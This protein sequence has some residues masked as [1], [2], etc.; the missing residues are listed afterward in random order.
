M[1]ITPKNLVAEAPPLDQPRVL[2]VDDE[3]LVL[4]SLARIFA[5]AGYQVESANDGAAA[6]ALLQHHAFDL[7]VSDIDMPGISGI[8]LLRIVREHDLDVPFLLVTGN[9]GLE[10]AMKAMEY[11][12]LRYLTKPVERQSLLEAAAKATRLHR[13]AKLKR[14]ANQ[15]LGN[16]DG[17]LGDRAGLEVGFEAALRSLW[18]A[19]QPIVRW[20]EKTVFAHEALMRSGEPRLPNPGAFFDAAERLNRLEGAG[21]AI[22]DLVAERAAHSPDQLLFVNLHPRDLLD[23]Q[24]YQP[25]SPLS[26]IAA[27][28]V[29]EITERA[30][31]DAVPDVPSRMR[32]LRALGYRIAV[33]DL[34]AGYAGLASFAQLN[35]EVVKLDMSLI[36]GIDGEQTKQKLVRSMAALCADM[37][38][39]MVAEGVETLAERQ[40]LISLGCDLLQG[41]WFARPGR[42]R[43]EVN[44]Q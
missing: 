16:L 28:V 38:T 29:L 7:V 32:R 26:L 43:P 17:Q 20:S 5:G 11:G 30:T 18:M 25:D 37:G 27:R 8:Q 21:R 41:Y 23:E 1:S 10:S 22:R 2:V 13:L 9:P 35:P 44:W 31:L 4:R 39:M 14:E 42:D 33:D 19:Y 12:A 6:Q 24:L 34:G 15:Y 36:R 40:T 3:P